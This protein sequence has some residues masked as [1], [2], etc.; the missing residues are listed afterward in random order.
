M[1]PPEKFLMFENRLVKVCRHLSKIARSTGV[2]CYR[3]Y[4]RDLPEFPLIIERYE[5]MAYVA[6]YRARHA[7]DETEYAEW[8]EGSLGVISKVMEI[9]PSN[10]F[11]KERKR[12]ED[13]GDQYLK[14]GDERTFREVGEG[15]L[16]FLVNLTDYLDT[17]LFLDH[18]LTREMVR[19]QS[20]G[21]KV[22]NLFCYTGSF[23]VYAAAGGATEIRS[24]DLSNTYLS[25][26]KRNME[27]NGL[28]DPARTFFEKADVL[29]YLP[30]APADYYD[31][32]ILDPPTFSNSKMMKD[33]L[34]IQEDHVTLINLALRALKP[35]GMLYFSTNARTFRMDRDHI[36]AAEVKDI[37]AAT[38]P[39]DFR[40]KLL[41]WCYRM[42]R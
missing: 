6:E 30:A 16:K 36:L 2:S 11:L 23:S 22:L 10:L 25:W 28:F 20:A 15:G 35:G 39:F 21:K 32:V 18:R 13:R 1:I 38:T 8:I 19:G 24:V 4:D 29:Q 33:I 27:I 42:K 14:T 12:K 7:L 34:D 41:R 5:D 31:L 17:G 40:G 9:A 26:A 3:V 37:T